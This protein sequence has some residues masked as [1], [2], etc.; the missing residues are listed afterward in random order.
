MPKHARMDPIFKQRFKYFI[1]SQIVTA[2]AAFTY[3]FFGNAMIKIP[4][5]YQWILALLSGFIRELFTILLLKCSLKSLGDTADEDI[6]YKSKISC[7]HFIESA[8]A[9]NMAILLGSVATPLT[10][11]IIIGL[12]FSINIYH[13]LKIVYQLKFSKKENA[14]DEGKMSYFWCRNCYTYSALQ[15]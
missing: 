13:G 4:L 1:I 2:Q 5:E 3:V 7:I 6:I 14:K 9:L 12:D 15:I 11:Y 8:H 10:T